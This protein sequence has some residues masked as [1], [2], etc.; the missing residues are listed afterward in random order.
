M[1]D[2]PAKFAAQNA[3]DLFDLLQTLDRALDTI[4]E[5]IIGCKSGFKQ[6]SAACATYDLLD[7]VTEFG[8][9]TFYLYGQWTCNEHANMQHQVSCNAMNLLPLAR[10]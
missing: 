8:K 1:A 7:K 3:V 4:V 2:E 10:I 9:T 6:C 5:I